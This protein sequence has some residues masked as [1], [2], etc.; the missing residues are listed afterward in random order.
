MEF[1]GTSTL[2]QVMSKPRPLNVTTV[3]IT[4][5]MIPLPVSTLATF[6]VGSGR[7]TRQRVGIVAP[8]EAE[9]EVAV[10]NGQFLP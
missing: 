1:P 7:S 8:D 6:A 10:S 9:H 3:P 5:R 4:L 2:L